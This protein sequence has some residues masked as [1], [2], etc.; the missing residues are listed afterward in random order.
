MH[1]GECYK[2][3]FF[4]FQPRPKLFDIYESDLERFGGMP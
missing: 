4:V 1:Q 2:H 3:Q